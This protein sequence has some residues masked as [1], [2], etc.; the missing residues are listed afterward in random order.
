M[1]KVL[2]PLTMQ[3]FTPHRSNQRFACRQNQIRYN[4][5]KASNKRAIKAKIDKPLDRNRNVLIR[6]LG[7]DKEVIKSKDWF[8]ALGYKFSIFT[9]AAKDATDGK[10]I[11]CIYE[12]A[13]KDLGN[14]NFKIFLNA[15]Y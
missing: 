8:M 14:N 1:N 15:N 2:D 7:K 9:N 6:L 3:E 4:N 12:Y 11:Q 13:V 10:A 5:L